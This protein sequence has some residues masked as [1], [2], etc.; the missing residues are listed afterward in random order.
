M[1]FIKRYGIIPAYIFKKITKP[2]HVIL[3][4]DL[5]AKAE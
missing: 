2:N 1:K 4:L 3:A 5:L